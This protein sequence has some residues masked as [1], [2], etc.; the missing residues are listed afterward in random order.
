MTALAYTLMGVAKVLDML[1]S[2]TMILVVARVVISWVSADPFNPIVRFVVASTDPL[3]RPLRKYIPLIG[4]AL[5]LTPLV[6]LAAI[7]FLQIA[8]VGTIYAYA[9][10]VDPGACLGRT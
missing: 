8:L 2:F 5:D 7:Y 9:C 3:F 1:L 6:V 10:Q 4:G